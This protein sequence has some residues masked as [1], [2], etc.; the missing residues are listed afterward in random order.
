MHADSV[1]GTLARADDAAPF[2]PQRDRP[3]ARAVEG[4]DTHATLLPRELAPLTLLEHLHLSEAPP[5]CASVIESLHRLSDLVLWS[6]HD[7]D[8]PKPWRPVQ[9]P[10]SILRAALNLHK[11]Q[12]AKI[13]RMDGEFMH[14]CV[15]PD[16]KRK[17]PKVLGTARLKALMKTR[18]DDD[19]GHDDWERA[20]LE[21]EG[22]VRAGGSEAEE[23]AAA[24][25]PWDDEE[26]VAR[27]F[28]KLAA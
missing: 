12:G 2:G 7:L 27:A 18:D 6:K 10:Y 3:R 20:V 1:G 22:E 28:E 19:D 23:D 5:C 25:W 14:P 11:R 9:P 15:D 24:A 4:E 8:D 26:S 17:A 16:R 13:T 21:R